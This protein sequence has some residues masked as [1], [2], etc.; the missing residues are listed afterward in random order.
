[1]RKEETGKREAHDERVED[2]ASFLAPLS[3]FL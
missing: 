1:M 2:G 3:S